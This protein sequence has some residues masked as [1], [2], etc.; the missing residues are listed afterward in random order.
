MQK[1]VLIES[2]LKES[3]DAHCH[4]VHFIGDC[5]DDSDDIINNF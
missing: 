4:N 1:V 5:S 2:R 3:R